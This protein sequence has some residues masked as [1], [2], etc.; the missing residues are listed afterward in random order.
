MRLFLLEL[1]SLGVRTV[2][3]SVNAR[4]GVEFIVIAFWVRLFL[5]ELLSLGVMIESLESW[6]RIGR[7]VTNCIRAREEV[8]VVVMFFY[9]LGFGGL[10]TKLLEE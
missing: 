8:E 6:S 7:N 10:L 1:L 9:A 4:E 2:T 3:Y 5:L